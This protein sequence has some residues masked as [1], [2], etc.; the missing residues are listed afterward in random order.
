MFDE[1]GKK[2]SKQVENT[3]GKGEIAHVEQYLL[4][5]SVVS[6]RLELQTLKNQG[7]FGKELRRVAVS[8]QWSL[9]AGGLLVHVVS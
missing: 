3:V 7:L 6:K 9:L 2:F 5:R 8:E 1:N 4:F